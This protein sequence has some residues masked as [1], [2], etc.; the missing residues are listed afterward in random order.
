MKLGAQLYSIRTKLQTEEDIRASFCKLKKIGYENVQL[1]GL[2]SISAEELRDIAEET[3]LPIIGSHVSFERII[4]ETDTVIAEHRI[5][6]CPVIGLGAMPKDFR[7]TREGLELF[8]AKI[9]KPVKKICD[10]GFQFSYHNH[11]FELVPFE[12]GSGDFAFDIMIET[13]DWNFIMD[14]YW[15]EFA[16]Q[17]S[18]DYIKKIG[19]NRLPDIHFK[20]MAKDDAHSICPCGRGILDFVEIFEACQKIG[21][22]NILVEQDNAVKMSDP[23]GQMEIS[24]K[25][26]RPIIK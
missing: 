13:L 16:G 6:G 24:F 12:D 22:K 26:L 14:T 3:E 7:G 21:V 23:I 18:V 4:N 11:A 9:S 2:A 17:K 20:D 15:V 25:H 8:L 10:A 19:G 1:S 5:L